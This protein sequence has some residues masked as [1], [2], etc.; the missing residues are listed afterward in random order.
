MASAGAY[1][2]YDNAHAQMRVKTVKYEHVMENKANNSDTAAP[3]PSCAA[4][5]SVGAGADLGGPAGQAERGHR[6]PPLTRS[7]TLES[8]VE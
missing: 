6:K 8:K 4:V 5:G 7:L 2:Q 3:R 1:A